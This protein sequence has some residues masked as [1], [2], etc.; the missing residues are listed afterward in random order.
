MKTNKLLAAGALALS[1][2]MTPVA[3]LLNAM[4]VAAAEVTISG[5]GEQEILHNHTFTAYQV[6]AGSEENGVLSNIKWGGGIN[7]GAFL[8][9]LNESTDSAFKVNN[10]NVFKDVSN[11]AE[12]A[13][14][15]VEQKDN[16]TLLDAFA[17]LADMNK[18][19]DGI[20]LQSGS[21][22]IDPGYYV[23]IDTSSDDV[24]VGKP[25]AVNKTLLQVVGKVDIAVKTSI[26]TVEKK[27]W[28]NNKGGESTE[29]RSGYND[30]A[31]HE[32]GEDVPF[33]FYSKVPD[34]EQYSTYEYVLHDTMSSGLTFNESSVKIYIGTNSTTPLA[35]DKYTVTTDLTNGETFNITINNM[36]DYQ[37]L[38]G[39]PIRVDFTAKLNSNAVIGL[40]GNTNE[41]FLEYSNN[42]YDT[43]KKGE[44]P[45]DK[46]V[47]FT[48]E[49]DVTKVDNADENIKLKGA[50]FELKKDGKTAVFEKLNDN[51]N[52]VLRLVK[53]EE[54]PTSL[55]NNQTT[56]LISGNNGVF[57][58]YGLDDGTYTLHETKAP[59][60]YT[61]P[62]NGKDFTL[63]I[64]ANTDN[65]QDWNGTDD[66]LNTYTGTLNTNEYSVNVVKPSEGQEG[67]AKAEITIKNSSASSLPETGGMGT[68]M[69]YGVGAVMVA[70]AA[71][72]YVTNKRTRKD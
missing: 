46:V 42:P 11:A 49:V 43:T 47:V 25:T 21:N 56:T 26:P 57:K 69:I 58:I 10:E 18:T 24:I 28:E 41:V 4:P 48:Y 13:A 31:D 22:E 29:Y 68:T 9:A 54:N 6:F 39:Q 1:M 27:V 40:P 59:D 60:G 51:D 38:K 37:S 17:R 33:S 34:M 7:S 72:F 16:V 30:V 23:I 62:T 2:A 63:I 70:G 32:I 14:I 15:L 55:E 36:K 50:E 12:V 8:K 64:K 5:T 71:V 35:S 65:R 52:S 3:S 20:Q 53:W 19:G 66:A 67:S 45:H 61:I 44:T